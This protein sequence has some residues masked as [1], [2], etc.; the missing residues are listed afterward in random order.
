M[1]SVK[2]SYRYI[3]EAWKKPKQGLGPLWRDRLVEW[4][5]SSVVERVEKP[6]RLDRARALGYK[7]KP[8]FVVVRIRIG[9]GGRKRSRP[10]GGRRSKRQTS[11]K[12][13]KMNY[14]WVAEQR[15]ARKFPNME[16]LNSYWL[17]KDGMNY[18]YEVIFVD[19]SKPEIKADKDVS[20]ISNKKHKNRV[21]RG[22][23]SSAR[24]SRGLRKKG[25]KAMKVRPS[26]RA[27]GRKGK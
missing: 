26:L 18:W 17:A 12:V 13:V 25:K 2:S 3:A 20:W 4:R 8:G 16:V 10:K 6:T 9:R 5:K 21:F 11:K 7:A 27:H 22:L 23:T 14:Q 24:K 15:A 1:K 19:P